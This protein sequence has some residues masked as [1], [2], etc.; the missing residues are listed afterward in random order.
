MQSLSEPIDNALTLPE[1]SAP[2]SD[3]LDSSNSSCFPSKQFSCTPTK[4]TRGWNFIF[5]GFYYCR[6]IV[7]GTLSPLMLCAY[8]IGI[9]IIGALCSLPF[10]S[11]FLAKLNVNFDVPAN[12]PSS[13]AT[14][15]ESSYFPSGF[16]YTTNYLLLRT[17][18]EGVAIDPLYIDETTQTLEVQAVHV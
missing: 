16:A 11:K 7:I 5:K 8:K 14:A 4:V 3:P 12:A 1:Q 10:V 6:F 9:W 18:D 13:I 17:V 2:I 15:M